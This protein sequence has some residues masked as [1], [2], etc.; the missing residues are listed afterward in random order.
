MEKWPV[1]RVPTRGEKRVTSICKMTGIPS[2]SDFHPGFAACR[3]LLPA[4]LDFLSLP[5]I[6]P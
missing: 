5:V 6:A 1:R 2:L 3:L 4:V